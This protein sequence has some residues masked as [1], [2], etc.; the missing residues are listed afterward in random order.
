MALQCPAMNLLDALL[1]G[2]AAIARGRDGWG[3]FDFVAVVAAFSLAWPWGLVLHGL[4]VAV[5]VSEGLKKAE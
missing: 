2:Y 3:V 5:R 4:L 1:P